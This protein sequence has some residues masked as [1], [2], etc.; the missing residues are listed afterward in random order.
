MEYTTAQSTVRE[1]TAMT[2]AVRIW[3]M[4]I[5]VSSRL[6]RLFEIPIIIVP[7]FPI[8]ESRVIS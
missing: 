3:V 1:M 7:S 2:A 8:G 6:I 4:M 5:L